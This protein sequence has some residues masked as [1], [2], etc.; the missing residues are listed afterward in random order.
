MVVD[1]SVW[2]EILGGGPLGQR[3]QDL[4]DKATVRV[5]SLVVY[6][7]YRKIKQRLGEES[8]LEVVAALSCYEQLDLTREVAMLA[9]DLSLAHKL[10]MAD[11][12]VL[13]HAR[14]LNEDLVTLDN[15]FAGLPGTLIIRK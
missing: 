11:S 4:I 5:S 9:A 8:A 6:E 15:D 13:A 10:P 14:H 3:C 2:I 7:V 1:S 12:L